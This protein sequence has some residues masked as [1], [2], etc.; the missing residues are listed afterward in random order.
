MY[1][2]IHVY[3]KSKNGFH[4]SESFKTNTFFGFDWSFSSNWWRTSNFDLY[5][6]LMA[7]EQWGFFSVPHLL[8][9]GASVYNG[10]MTHACFRVFGS[11]AAPTWFSDLRLLRPGFDPDLPHAGRT[12]YQ[13]SLTE[14]HFP[15]CHN[16]WQIILNKHP[17]FN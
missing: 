11:G 16:A 2:D 8:R 6:A 4:D 7:I 17:D 14:S 12:L 10:H 5:S 1:S 13:L 3:D 9:Q 15:N